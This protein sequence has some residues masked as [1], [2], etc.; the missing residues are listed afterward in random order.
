MRIFERPQPRP[1]DRRRLR[2][3]LPSPLGHRHRRRRE[4]RDRG[5]GGV[6]DLRHDAARGRGIGVVLY[7]CRDRH[8]S[9]A[10]GG[11][12]ADE[13]APVRHVKRRGLLEPD[14]AI[15]PGAFV[16]PAFVLGCVHAHD[17]R[18]L[19]A[20]GQQ[21][22]H[23]EPERHVAAQVAAH[24]V[25]VEDHDAIAED[26]V[27]LDRDAAARVG[28]G[29]EERPAV[30]A[31]A[32]V[33]ERA[34]ERL[35][36]VAVETAILVEGQIDRPVVRQIDGG[37]GRGPGRVVERR[38]GDAAA[39]ANQAAG[40]RER[41]A[42]PVAEI[43]RDVVGVA[44]MEAPAEVGEQALAAGGGCLRRRRRAAEDPGHVRQQ[45]RAARSRRQLQPIASGHWRRS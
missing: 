9:R 22:R 34:A 11:G 6:D 37:P 19:A 33:G 2:H 1:R 8:C 41:T 12:A 36:A 29:D 27:E 16:E 44:E 7:F 40:F 28:P 5:A 43:L 25:A 13:R 23:V 18:I 20:V 15:D 45:R 38:L 42:A 39:T 21:I 31:D 17:E 3:R 4:R 14:V 24:E 35:R 30:P 32:R 10:R 26:A